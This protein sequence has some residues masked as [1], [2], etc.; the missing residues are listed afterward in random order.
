MADI[1]P[2][3]TLQQQLTKIEGKICAAEQHAVN[4]G[5]Q[6]GQVADNM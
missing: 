6:P 3:A 4:V 1:S 5:S 2:G